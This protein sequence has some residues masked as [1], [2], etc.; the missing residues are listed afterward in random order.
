MSNIIIRHIDNRKLLL[1]CILL[2][3]HSLILFSF[4]F[5]KNIVVIYVFVLEEAMYSYCCLCVVY[6]F[7][8]AATLTEVFSCLFLSC[9]ANARV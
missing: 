5:Y 7:L 3:L 8:D 2:L 9:K 4:I 6:I 1:I